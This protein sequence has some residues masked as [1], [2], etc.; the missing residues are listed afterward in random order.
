M[1]CCTTSIKVGNVLTTHT[2]VSPCAVSVGT[3]VYQLAVASCFCHNCSLPGCAISSEETVQYL[4]KPKIIHAGAFQ[5]GPVKISDFQI[6]GIQQP[7]KCSQHLFFLGRLYDNTREG[8]KPLITLRHLAPRVL[9]TCKFCIEDLFVLLPDLL[10]VVLEQ[11]LAQVAHLLHCEWGL[12]L[13]RGTWKTQ[14]QVSGGK[15]QT[16]FPAPA[17]AS[18]VTQR[19]REMEREM[20]RERMSPVWK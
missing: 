5:E 6:P 12:V 19:E 11:S 16:S 10:L 7:C 14:S 3:I 15:G 17:A 1:D 18:W 4:N 9:I 20:E 8:G 2:A 13:S